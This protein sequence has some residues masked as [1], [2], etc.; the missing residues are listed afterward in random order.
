[1]QIGSSKTKIIYN[2]DNIHLAGFAHER[3]ASGKHDDLWIRC[4]VG[5]YNDELYVF[6]NLDLCAVDH[7]IVDKVKTI[8][9]SKGIKENN[10]FIMATHTHSGYA[11]V[12]DTNNGFLA[13]AKDIFGEV[14]IGLIEHIVSLMIE[15]FDGAVRDI[16]D[17]IVKIGSG[18]CHQVGT[19]RNNPTLVGDDS[20]VTV[21]FEQVN[22]KF[23]MLSFACHPTVLS[24]DN[25]LISGDFPNGL[26]VMYKQD[27][28]D[29][30]MFLNSDCGDISTRFTRKGK[31]FSEVERLA[32]LLYEAS[33]SVDY[34]QIDV[35][36]VLVKTIDLQMQVKAKPNVEDALRFYD[37]SKLAYEKAKADGVSGSDLRL[38]ENRLEGARANVL[39]AKSE[40][41]VDSLDLKIGILKLNDA[42]GVFIPGECFSELAHLLKYENIRIIGYANGYNMYLADKNA[43]EDNVYE[44]MSSPFEVGEGERMIDI[45]NNVIC[46]MEE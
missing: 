24:Y 18:V 30:C 43:F 16:Q 6:Y 37:D 8:L 12:I 23:V 17:T 36:N 10:I 14:N 19:N 28:Y 11:G 44:A 39:Y 7:L 41:Q 4:I 26:E 2:E 33:N 27:G 3:W 13:I 45:I 21:I 31:G 46:E 25:T 22:K 40:V 5:K 32:Q 1:M 35:D 34:Y 15:C 9:M 42:Y 20:F 29:F 38:L